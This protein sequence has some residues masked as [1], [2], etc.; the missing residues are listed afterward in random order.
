MAKRGRPVLGADLVEALGS[1]SAAKERLAVIIRTLAGEA[2]VEE[3]CAELLIGRSAFHKL[4]RRFM[5]EAAALLEPRPSGRRK[6]TV[7]QE[8]RELE[9]LKEEN[10]RLRLE[11]AAQQIREEIAVLMPHLLRERPGKKTPPRRPFRNPPPNSAA[12]TGGGSGGKRR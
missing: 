7:S 12:H 4:R 5:V 10:S 11:L 2:T 6:R 8:Q 3:A 1:S 9:R